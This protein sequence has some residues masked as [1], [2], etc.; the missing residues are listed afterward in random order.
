[1]NAPASEPGAP[2]W[3]VQRFAGSV[4]EAHAA[5]LTAAPSGRLVRVH[6]FGAAAVVLGSSQPC[7]VVDAAAAAKADVAIVRRRGGGGAVLLVPGDVVWIDV[8]LPAGDPL[9]HDDIVRATDWLGATW[10]RALG[11]LG[12]TATAH[13]GPLRRAPWSDLVC[14]AGLGPGE[15]TVGGR[16]AVGI[17]QRRTRHAARF[18]SAALLRWDPR[19]LTSL[20]ALAPPERARADAALAGV[21]AG[22]PVAATEL[23]G[24]F[25]GALTAHGSTGLASP[26]S[27]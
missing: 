8:V 19:A 13:P 16:K 23:V 21:A 20:L 27:G 26:H 9:W 2:R 6:E 10:E 5:D 12:V 25:V 24:A 14:F 4:A 17:S 1:V 18:Q 11:T 3:Q 22:I 15:V 7:T